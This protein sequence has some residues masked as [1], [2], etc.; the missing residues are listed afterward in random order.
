MLTRESS[1]RA[2]LA[3]IAL[4]MASAV[5]VDTTV[6]Y[7]GLTV[8]V[9]VALTTEVG[10]KEALL[11]RARLEHQ[12]T[13]GVLDRVIADHFDGVLVVDARHRIISASKLAQEL[14]SPHCEGELSGH[15]I[16]NVLPQDMLNA[17]SDAFKQK[18]AQS[19]LSETR[20]A[21]DGGIRIFEYVATYSA[22]D[23]GAAMR[24]FSHAIVCLTFRDVTDARRSQ[25][26]ISYMAH[27]DVLTGALS[28]I[29]LFELISAYVKDDQLRARGLTVLVLDLARFKMVN[30]SLGHAYGDEVLKQVVSRL[31]AMEFEA[32]ARLGGDCFAVMCAHLLGPDELET[33]C[34][35]LLERLSEVYHVGEH[36]ALVGV[37]MGLTDSRVSGFE[38]GE[39]LSHADMAL[40][41]AKD[42]PGNAYAVY[43]PDMD[44]VLRDKQEM[45]IALRQ[46]IANGELFV[47]YQVQVDLETGA[48][49]GAEAL[50]RWSHPI[51]GSVPPA[52]F[53]PV[54]EETGIILELG[55]WILE[56]AC[57]EAQN[58]PGNI[59]LAVNVSPLQ[60]EFGDVVGDVQRALANSGIAPRRLEIEVTEGLLVSN[61]SSIVEQLEA[62]RDMG[63]RIAL[64]DFGTGYSSLSYLGRLP[65]DKIKIDQSF[66]KGLPGNQESSAIIRAVMTLA[67]SLHKTVVAEGIENADQ[68][69][70]L[71][72]AGCHIGQGYHFGRPFG[73]AE[74]GQRLH[75]EARKLAS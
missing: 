5:I 38:P 9:V 18:R 50:A 29:R 33:Y 41:A 45:E 74:I 58:W 13:Q 61:A 39:L 53:I 15:P 27:H 16:G 72:L 47:K 6:L 14:L 28:R 1:L 17:V 42:V 62:L 32:V 20:I 73:A 36:Q 75:R 23:T 19:E 69:W 7:A 43:A 37:K 49:R 65:L 67:E 57:A 2:V 55:R 24:A 70:L 56:T 68:A 35:E 59:S 4:V 34:N 52:R 63:V 25:A 46:A 10:F 3:V 71:R 31:R 54:A 21:V 40:S 64:D 26:R 22:L 11:A 66:V 60:F 8:F 51:L 48:I 44:E 12:A 30:D